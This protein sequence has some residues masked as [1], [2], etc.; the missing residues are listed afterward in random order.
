MGGWEGSV[1]WEVF[2]HD[3]QGLNRCYKPWTNSFVL[4]LG[5]K[6]KFQKGN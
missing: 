4:G 5:K 1:P 2:L 6:C 3:N